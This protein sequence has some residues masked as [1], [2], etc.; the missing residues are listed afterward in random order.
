MDELLAVSFQLG[1]LLSRWIPILLATACGQERVPPVCADMCVSATIL[2]GACL[3][4][5][6]VSFEEAGYTSAAGF[7]DSCDTWAWERAYF[8]ADALKEGELDEPGWL[9]A[10]CT[11]GLQLFDA[12]E[13]ECADYL[14]YDW[15]RV[16]GAGATP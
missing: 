15:L 6:G 1:I 7:R 11:G 10:T 14:A 12:P 2:Y 13:T 4:D 3:N 5:W 8:E 16:P 9:E